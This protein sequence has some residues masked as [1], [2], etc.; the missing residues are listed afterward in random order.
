M[1]PA[2]MPPMTHPLWPLF[3]LRIRTGPLELRLPTD[4]D[5]V[6]LVSLARAGIHPPDEMP[7]G[8]AWTKLPSPAFER[9]FAQY[10]WSRRSGW[11]PDDW[12]LDLMVA[13][14]GMPIGMQGLYG[15]RFAIHRLV[16]TG[17]WLGQAWQGQGHGKAMRTAVLALA[18]DHL[19]AQVAESKAFLDNPRSSGVS[20][21]LGYVENGIGRIAPEDVSRDTQRFRL[22]LEGW[23]SRPR[24]AV[25]VE[26]LAPCLE[27]FGVTGD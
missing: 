12:G 16:H 9:G 20:R 26:G 6:E 8:I 11:T 21:A 27:L 17:S 4:D 18:F 22:T 14:D 19:G 7:F 23:R 2:M 3:D 13:L 15:R 5:L 25:E 24:P 1:R 10:H